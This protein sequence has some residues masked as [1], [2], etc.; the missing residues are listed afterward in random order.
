MFVDLDIGQNSITIPGAIAG[1]VVNEPVDP[2]K[3][4]PLADHFLYF[5]GHA[6]PR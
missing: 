2:V 1:T 4:I 3:G 6:N 5:Y